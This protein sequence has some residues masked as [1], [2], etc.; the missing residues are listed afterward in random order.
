MT[1]ASAPSGY[2]KA[3]SIVQKYQ[4]NMAEWKQRTEGA[5][6][7]KPKRK[8]VLERAPAAGSGSETPAAKAKPKR[9][10]NGR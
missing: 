2:N 4:G 3:E 7:E 8:G 1:F 10:S 9:S 5:T 6:A